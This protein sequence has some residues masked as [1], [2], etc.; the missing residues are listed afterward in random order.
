MK[1]HQFSS[2]KLINQFLSTILALGIVTF[3]TSLISGG[4]YTMLL[5]WFQDPIGLQSLIE[6]PETYLI[7]YGINLA[8][9]VPVLI[10]WGVLCYFIINLYRKEDKSFKLS[11][12][13]SGINTLLLFI[14]MIIFTLSL[15]S[16]VEFHY[17]MLLGELESD[18]L[19][20]LIVNILEL[21][22]WVRLLSYVEIDAYIRKTRK[23]RIKTG[24]IILIVGVSVSLLLKFVF[25]G[26]ELQLFGFSIEAYF[27]YYIRIFG[28]LTGLEVV[29]AVLYLIG[30][31]L[32]GIFR[33]K[34][35]NNKNKLVLEQK[36]AE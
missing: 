28:V 30:G 32:I 17:E 23:N 11:G 3:I 27:I 15:F 26:D 8:Q 1:S 24:I 6:Q 21:V 7:F 35:E 19:L 18:F 20:Q 25:I 4:K 29:K 33:D 9:R 10:I 31:L 22:I 34:S 12:L 5:I 2:H 13:F 16:V 14:S 36:S